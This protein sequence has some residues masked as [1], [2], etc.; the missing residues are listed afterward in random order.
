MI[1]ALIAKRN[2]A[3]AF[4]ALNR[5]DLEAFLKDWRDDAIFIYPGDIAVSGTHSGKDAIRTWFQNM[6][7]Q[8]PT[9]AF[10]LKHIAV[11]NLFDLIGNNV[12]IV[13]WDIKVTNK[14]GYSAE[15]SGIT[16]VTTQSGKGVH[17]KDYIFNTGEVWRKAWGAA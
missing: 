12:I 10:T 3:A 17:V 8:Y 9:I 5:H 4:D 7:D 2:I 11:N 1:G 16:V 6:I 13:E 14:D 15:N